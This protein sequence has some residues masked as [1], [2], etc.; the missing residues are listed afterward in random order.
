MDSKVD[1]HGTDSIH[2]EERNQS[3]ALKDGAEEATD[4]AELKRILRKIDIHV[5]PILAVLYL[6]SFLD[7]GSTSPFRL[8]HAGIDQ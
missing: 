6:L 5:V 1:V 8:H 7:R 4:P 3:L 2:M